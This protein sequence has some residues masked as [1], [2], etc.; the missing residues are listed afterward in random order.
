MTE[1]EGQEGREGQER[2]VPWWAE[3]YDDLLAD[4]LLTREPGQLDAS[5]DFLV[6]RL[7]VGA[8][9]RVLDQCCGIG[10][11]ALPLATRGVQ[12]LGIDQA[13][14]YVERARTAADRAGV[15]AE[16]ITG[17]AC[18]FV[19][20]QPVDAVFNWWTSFGYAAED[21]ANRE[22]LAR[23]FDALRPGGRFALDTM[24]VPGVLR[25]FQRDS[26]LR[27]STARGEVIL[28]RESRIDFA[29]GRMHKDWTYVVNDRIEVRHHSSVRLYPPDAIVTMLRGI[30]FI[31]I[32][33]LGDVTGVP[34]AL[35]SPR[36]IV[37][38]RRPD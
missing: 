26:V 14:R 5:V 13:D 11:L 30:G 7:D 8:G 38:A 10:S 29:A 28:L 24:N 22:M 23:A 2:D 4:Q 20:E 12:V 21:T 15:P 17:D 18:E 32:D 35:D 37:L 16:F 27:R 31:D 9:S 34:L 33:L 19:P 6:D 25:G 36:L 3:L 1:R